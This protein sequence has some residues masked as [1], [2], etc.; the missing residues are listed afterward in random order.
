MNVSLN[1]N[2]NASFAAEINVRMPFYMDQSDCR[3]LRWLQMAQ[4]NVLQPPINKNA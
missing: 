1:Y 4:M 3:K 2:I